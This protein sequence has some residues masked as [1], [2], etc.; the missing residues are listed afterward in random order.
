MCNS[1][2]FI[3]VVHVPFFATEQNNIFSVYTLPEYVK[4]PLCPVF[5]QENV[6]HL[7]QMGILTE[8]FLRKIKGQMSVICS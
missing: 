7:A 5:S 3:Y 1:L 2:H 6:L 8:D 4:M